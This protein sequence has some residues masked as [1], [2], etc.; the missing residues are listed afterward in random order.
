MTLV[1]KRPV[2]RRWSAG[3]RRG[4]P[5]VCCS[6]QRSLEVPRCRAGGRAVAGSKPVS[7]I[8]RSPAKGGFSGAKKAY[9]R[10]ERGPIVVK[11]L[12]TLEDTRTRGSL[13]ATGGVDHSH[14]RPGLLSGLARASQCRRMR[15]K[16]SM[17]D[18]SPCQLVA[19]HNA[20]LARV[21]RPPAQS[22]RNSRVRRRGRHRAACFAWK[23]LRKRVC[24]VRA[25]G[26]SA[27]RSAVDGGARRDPH[28][29]RGGL[30]AQ[31]GERD[32]EVR[33]AASRTTGMQT[34]PTGT[35][36]V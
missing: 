34:V 32:P 9:C 1:A 2:K 29:S 25:D 27:P 17:P 21:R 24:Q 5:C 11:F 16:E 4:K 13:E 12:V 6:P 20:T 7:P 36:W 15:A 28:A 31:A 14:R 23:T 35:A 30:R 8:V 22:C 18:P 33:R 3:G 10:S 26:G 19:F